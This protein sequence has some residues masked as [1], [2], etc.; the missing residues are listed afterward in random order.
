[1]S[2][3]S[4]LQ[5]FKATLVNLQH[6]SSPDAPEQQTSLE[7][8]QKKKP[9]SSSSKSSFVRPLV[10]LSLLVFFFFGLR[11]LGVF[12][13]ISVENV[14]QMADSFGALGPVIFVLLAAA[15]VSLGVPGAL[16]I[17]GGVVAFGPGYG[18]LLSWW[19]LVIGSVVAVEWVQRVGGSPLAASENPFIKKAITLLHRRP[20][21]GVIVVRWIVFASPP[22]NAALAFAGVRPFQNA[23]GTLVGVVPLLTMVTFA[24]HSLTS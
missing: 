8:V 5:R 14:R 10:A 2:N 7:S 4:S 23:L 19:G 21:L 6:P 18:A 9:E 11:S 20:I 3:A 16:F 15:G 17:P 24:T 13:Q 1:M 12:E 22:A